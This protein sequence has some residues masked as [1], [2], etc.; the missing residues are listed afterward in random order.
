MKKYYKPKSL[1][2]FKNRIGKRIFR[3]KSTCKCD[4]CFKIEANGLVVFD[5]FHARYLAD[6]DVDY[7]SCG[8]YLNYRDK[9]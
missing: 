9:L 6:T 1:T 3:D 5:F 8:A 4:T 2:W 7:A